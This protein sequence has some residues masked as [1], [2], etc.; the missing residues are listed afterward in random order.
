VN[1]ATRPRADEDLVA[2]ARWIQADHPQA[3]RRFLD[4]AFRTFDQLA[5]F[6]K[7]APAARLRSKRLKTVRVCVMPPPFNRFLV[8]YV[9]DAGEVVILRVL[10]G[11][12]NW[13]AQMADFFL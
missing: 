5:Q 13:R 12:Q 1:Y 4:A 6:P 9:V 8:F 2:C 7:S 10:Y 3:A 11:T